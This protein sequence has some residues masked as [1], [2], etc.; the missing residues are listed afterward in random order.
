MNKKQFN[1]LAA[2]YVQ[3]TNTLL[4]KYVTNETI[5]S[6]LGS[7]D[8]KNIL[9]LGCGNG[10]FC[11]LYKTLG[12]TRV[13]GLDISEK[14]IRLAKNE[15]LQKPLGINYHVMDITD[16]LQ[17]NHEFDIVTAIFV[18]NY[19]ENKNDL[20][21]IAENVSKAL[22]QGGKFLS[23]NVNPDIKLPYNIKYG[24]SINTDKTQLEDGLAFSVSFFDDSQ[25]HIVDTRCI[26]WSKES[27]QKAFSSFGF[28]VDWHWPVISQDGISKFGNKFWSEFIDNPY[29]T[30]FTCC[31]E[32][33]YLD[34]TPR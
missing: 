27:Y 28:N 7:V 4:R 18:L 20:R 17:F 15:E 16:H 25:N 5:F 24:R 11:R 23:I 2:K 31:K 19:I 14:Q 22:T 1:E 6:N 30:A 26:N 9:D 29:F 32:K 33:E 8:D 3:T 34:K 10:Y 13:V 12:A 21:K